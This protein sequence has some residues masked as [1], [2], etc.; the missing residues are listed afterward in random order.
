MCNWANV[1]LCIHIARFS[2]RKE[3]KFFQNPNFSR[4]NKIPKHRIAFEIPNRQ[5]GFYQV[6][7]ARYVEKGNS[8]HQWQFTNGEI[9]WEP[10][11]ENPLPQFSTCW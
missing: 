5:Q 2:S 9:S 1:G 11:K 10:K 6:S 3:A 7:M 8:L 4:Y